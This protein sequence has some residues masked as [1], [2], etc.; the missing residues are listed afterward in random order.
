MRWMQGSVAVALFAAALTALAGP[1]PLRGRNLHGQPVASD[2]PDAVFEY[3]PNYD[4]TWLRDWNY[5]LSSGYD[6]DGRMNWHEASAWAAGLKVGDFDGWRLPHTLWPDPTCVLSQ[7]FG[8]YGE[9]TGCTGSPMSYL[10]KEVL[11]NTAAGSFDPGVF[12]NLQ[13]HA[14]WSGTAWDNM[15]SWFFV[16]GAGN[17]GY[18]SAFDTGSFFAVAV[19]D[20][21]VLP[22]P[23][24]IALSALAVVLAALGGSRGRVG[25]RNARLV[26]FSPGNSRIATGNPRWTSS[27]AQWCPGGCRVSRRTRGWSRPGSKR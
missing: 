16:P 5:A 23:S 19:R 4:I 17:Q 27:R 2:S 15:L 24:S 26:V 18:Q 3:D 21:D 20:G 14:Y 12:Q 22:E 1:I 13:R 8:G 25:R 7:Q 11:G 9:Y 10:W 6:S